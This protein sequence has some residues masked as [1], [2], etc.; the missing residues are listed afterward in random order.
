[1][2]RD[3][4]GCGG[5]GCQ[6]GDGPEDQGPLASIN[7]IALHRGGQRPDDASLRERAWGELLRQEAVRQNVLSRH[8]G[9]DAPP[10]SPDDQQAIE[11]MLERSIQ[12]PAPTDEECSRYYEANKSHFV[13]GALVHA[14]HILFAVTAG[15]DVHKLVVRAEQALLE[16]SRQGVPE[17]R[18]GELARELSNCP[19]GAVGGD[20]GWIG[21]HDCADELANEL[22]HQKNPL[23]GIGLRPRL[24]H[25]RYGFHI[26]EVLGRKQGRQPPFEEVK[27]RIAVQLAQRSRAKAL[28]QYMQLLAGQAVIEGI[29]LEGAESPLVQ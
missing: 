9:A 1:M 4:T 24:V 19:S 28:H 12:V 17:G 21:P 23:R 22:F 11:A 10:L 2:K 5:A 20:L 18:F 15:V 29:A 25:S 6:C 26:V 27:Q 16:L 14:R 8:D 13:Q 3:D 7:G